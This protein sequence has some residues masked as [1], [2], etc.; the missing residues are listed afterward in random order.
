MVWDRYVV[1]GWGVAKRVVSMKRDG[2]RSEGRGQV[3]DEEK[4]RTCRTI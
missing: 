2:D 3:S 4:E 1:C